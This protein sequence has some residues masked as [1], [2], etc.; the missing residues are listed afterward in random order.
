MTG[1]T[2]IQPILTFVARAAVQLSG[3]TG[4]SEFYRTI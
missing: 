4:W 1:V 2:I 3:W